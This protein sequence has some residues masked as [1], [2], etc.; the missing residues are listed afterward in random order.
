MKRIIICCDGTWDYRNI[1]VNGLPAITN[2]VKVANAVLD[3]YLGVEQKLFY[4]PGVGTH[5]SL[6]R[7]LIDGITG[8][9]LFKNI[10]NAYRYLVQHYEP[11]DE[12][13]LL[14]FSRGA[15]TVRELVGLIQHCGIVRIDS[16]NKVE[17][18]FHLYNSR[19]LNTPEGNAKTALFRQQYA[20][21][22]STPI[23]F[24]GVW[25]TVGTLGNPLLLN[26]IF[27]K[28]YSF[29]D[30]NLSPT[31]AYAYQAIAID[32]QRIFFKPA[33]WMKDKVDVH[34]VME[35]VWFIGVHDDV[36]GG[37]AI[38]LSDITLQW[39]I[40]KATNLGLG[41]KAI[42]FKPDWMQTYSNSRTGL[43]RLF[44]PYYRRIGEEIEPEGKESCQSI[45]VSVLE[46]YQQDK[47]Y[48][49]RNLVDYLRRTNK[50]GGIM[51]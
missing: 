12:L 7:R 18:G 32:E 45:H 13:F 36:G 27:T 48:R 5:G 15:F 2:V 25:D 50:G 29:H 46:R 37:G 38:G 6:L 3:I 41:F 11:G 10:L 47:T 43:Y 17:E 39:I 21:E 30:Y 19:T 4:E 8:N 51:E 35:Q 49:P 31:V 42:D 34:Q 23:K 26:G 33:L 20:V 16:I 22:E 28:R 14:G 24:L 9:G 40:D 1:Q 44:P